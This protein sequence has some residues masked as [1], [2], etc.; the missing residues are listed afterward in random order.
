VRE[1]W[2]RLW[3]IAQKFNRVL[4]KALQADQKQGMEMNEHFNQTVEMVK[5]GSGSFREPLASNSKKNCLG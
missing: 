2:L 3:V 1:N 5:L 4:N